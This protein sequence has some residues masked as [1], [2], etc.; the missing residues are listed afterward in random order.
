[1]S[2]TGVGGGIVIGVYPGTS[3]KHTAGFD[4]TVPAGN[5]FALAGGEYRSG[6]DTGTNEVRLGLYS[7]ASGKPGEI[8]ETFTV[9]NAL[10][11]AITGFR[12][13]KGPV[14]V[15]G[16]RYWLIASMTNPAT[17]RAYW[18]VTDPADPGLHAVSVNNERWMISTRGRGGFQI[19][20]YPKIGSGPLPT[21][22]AGV[23]VSVGGQKAPL[24]YVSANRVNLQIPYEVPQG[25]SELVLR[26]GEASTP[27]SVSIL[28]AAPGIMVDDSNWAVVQNAD[29]TMNSAANPARVGSL[30]S[31]Y[32]TGAG[33]VSPAV[34]TGQAAPN[35]PLSYAANVT[36]SID[37]VPAEVS[38]AGLTPG[39]VGLLQVNLQVPPLTTGTYG[40]Q[41][42]VGSARSNTASIAVTQ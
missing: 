1:M 34:P 11:T 4:F 5:D 9:T 15:A 24:S 37:G 23:T 27:V 25:K 26:K 10:T 42:A 29:Y 19:F 40:I 16:R 39:A 6:F 30:V 31:V 14:L 22:L 28:D 7:D 12:S 13:A 32:G 8:L 41:I 17:S 33:A 3:N 21:T 36:A 35:S 18:H 20:G 2:K 38:F